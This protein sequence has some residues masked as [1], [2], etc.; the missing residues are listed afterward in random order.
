MP[1]LLVNRRYNKKKRV[2]TRDVLGE[3]VFLEGYHAV[4]TG[5]RNMGG[6]PIYKVVK[7]RKV[8]SYLHAECVKPP[9]NWYFFLMRLSGAGASRLPL[10]FQFALRTLRANIK[11]TAR[12]AY[13]ARRAMASS[14]ADEI[15]RS[16]RAWSAACTTQA[17]STWAGRRI[18][19]ARP[20]VRW[21]RAPSKLCALTNERLCLPRGLRRFR[22]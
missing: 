5:N 14:K 6:A 17:S 22:R 15:G 12:G 19:Y 1:H 16:P 4:F 20:S 3:T 13:V 18:W 21:L 7:N 10:P 2:V 8:P 9:Q 11:D